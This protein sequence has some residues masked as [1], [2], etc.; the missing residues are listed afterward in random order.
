MAYYTEALDF[1]DLTFPKPSFWSRI[2]GAI[3][4]NSAIE[5][6]FQRVHDLQKLSDRELNDIGLRRD[7]I[8]RYALRDIYYI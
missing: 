7:E 3:V 5:E 4:Q 8:A 2:R 1:S 6:R